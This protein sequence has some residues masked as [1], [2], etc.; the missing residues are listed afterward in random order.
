VTNR[1]A[2]RS[3]SS[4]RAIACRRVGRASSISA[5]AIENKDIS[6][7]A[8][9]TQDDLLQPA[10]GTLFERANAMMTAEEI[11]VLIRHQIKKVYEIPATH[12]SDLGELDTLL[13]TFHW[14]YANAT[15]RLDDF[16]HAKAT[17]STADFLRYMEL[18]KSQQL[19]HESSGTGELIARWKKLG[20]AIGIL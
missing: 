8:W 14:L 18:T 5:G 17:E 20:S 15:G 3:I 6:G 9:V 4:A 16:V 13:F 10:L 2:I 19:V 12:V 1:P 7:L 11:V